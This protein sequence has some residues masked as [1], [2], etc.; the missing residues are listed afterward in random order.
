MSAVYTRLFT[1]TPKRSRSATA[2]ASHS[3]GLLVCGGLRNKARAK[4]SESSFKHSKSRSDISGSA[5][6]RQPGA[7]GL[8]DEIS[9]PK[10]PGRRQ[11]QLLQAAIAARQ[12]KRK[13]GAR[14]A[15]LELHVG[16]PDDK[17]RAF[18][19]KS[20]TSPL[21]S[22][23]HALHCLFVLRATN[24]HSLGRL[25]TLLGMRGLVPRHH[26]SI[27][28]SCLLSGRSE[29][30]LPPSVSVASIGKPHPAI[31]AAAVCL[32]LHCEGQGQHQTSSA[33]TGDNHQSGPHGQDL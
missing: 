22:S 20:E 25:I 24:E 18:N 31:T 19:L 33:C 14:I 30:E 1:V 4:G 3:L 12:C 26:A 32:V 15:E 5:S 23:Y 9:P 7:Q 13:R 10:G 2:Q 16:N 21:W 28:G 11:V 27:A 6:A 17:P 8:R 29:R